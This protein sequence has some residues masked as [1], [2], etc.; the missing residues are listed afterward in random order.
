MSTELRVRVGVGIP[1][2]LAEMSLF[3]RVL[4][5]GIVIIE[6]TMQVYIQV[7]GCVT[8]GV[9]L[10]CHKSLCCHHLHTAA[11]ECIERQREHQ[12]MPI[13]TCIHSVT[14]SGQ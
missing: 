2:L 8:L 7:S 10:S 13:M 14:Q 5:I 11:A 9:L 4:S 12:M 1:A 6:L 3:F